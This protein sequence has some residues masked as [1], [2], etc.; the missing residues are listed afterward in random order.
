[1]DKTANPHDRLFR[2]TWSDRD[3]AADFMR[4]YLPENILSVADLN[5]LEI[6]KESFIEEDLKDYYSDILYR[7]MFEG[8]DGYIYLLFEHKSYSDRLIFL[9]LLEYML[10]IWRLVIKQKKET[11]LLPVIVP[12]VLYHGRKEW[13]CGTEFSGMF[14]GASRQ[15][16]AYIPDFGFV[17]RD[18]TRYSDDEIR[19]TVSSRVVMMLMK[20]IFDPDLPEKLPAIF[21]MMREITESEGGL[22]FLEKILRYIFSAADGFTTDG[23][24]RM[25][26]ESVSADKGGAVMTLEEKLI[27]EGYEKGI[28]Q[29]VEQGIRQGVE[30]GIY[31]GIR[32]GLLEAVELGLGL[33]FGEESLTMMS[34]IRNITDTERLRGIKLM[35]KTAKNISELKAAVDN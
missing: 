7:M 10:K 28:R 13:S 26:E 35:I 2:E 22:R 23:L 25:V 20:H 21:S 14:T 18:L 31:Q 34:Q 33:K 32:E 8:D 19:G 24:K 3:T 6:C 17:L 30:Q 1:M 16:S 27:N 29:G 9:Q 15:L 5:S 4:H 12:I 11:V